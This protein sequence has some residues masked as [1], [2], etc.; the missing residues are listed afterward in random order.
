M[1]E[2]ML[3]ELLSVERLEYEVINEVFLLRFIIFCEVLDR[4]II[5]KITDMKDFSSWSVSLTLLQLC[6]LIG[7]DHPHVDRVDF[8]RSQ[9]CPLLP[10]QKRGGQEDGP[11]GRPLHYQT[12]HQHAEYEESNHHADQGGQLEDWEH[13]M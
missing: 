9:A 10:L 11:L 1:M 4:E 8:C 6:F 12:G 3:L 5:P 7:L 13:H 2:V